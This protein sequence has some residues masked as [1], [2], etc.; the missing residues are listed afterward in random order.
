MPDSL[1]AALAEIAALRQRVQRLE[2]TNA[3]LAAR[4]ERSLDD[5]S[6]GFAM[7]QTAT[8]LERL[9]GERTAHLER[10]RRELEDTNRQLMA[11]K[12]AAEAAAG[13]KARF[14]ANM[15]HEIRTPMNGILGMTELLAATALDEH[16]RQMANTIKASADALL[17]VVNDVLDYSKI[18]AGKLELEEAT[19]DVRAVLDDCANLLATAAE[20]RG[21]E[22]V[23]YVDPRVAPGLRGDAARLRQI[24]LNLTGNAVKF[25]LEGQVVLSIDLLSE[26]ATTQ[27]LRLE[28][29]DT[30]VGI[31]PDT[32]ARL[33]TPFTQADA[34]TTRRFGGTGLGLAI[35]KHLVER[36][37][38]QIGAH[39]TVG[40]GSRFWIELTLPI[41]PPLPV[42]PS[43][44]F[45]RHAI[46]VVDD[47]ETNRELLALQLASVSIGIDLASDAEQALV[48]LRLA[49]ARGRPFTMAL[50]DMAMPDG[51][52]LALVEAIRRDPAIPPL[53]IAIASSL[54]HRPPESE[55]RRLR[56]AQWVGKPLGSSR[57]FDLLQELATDASAT[58]PPAAVPVEP[59][60]LAGC[61]VLVAEDNDINRRVLAGMLAKLG[62]TPTFAAD[63]REA[64][65]LAQKQRFDVILMDCRMPEMDGYAATSAIRALGGAAGAVPIV[66]L[67][68]N[69]LSQDRSACFASGMND[70][71]AKPVKLDVLRATLQRWVRP[72]AATANAGS[73]A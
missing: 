9:V 37:G 71:L 66:A 29:R 41:A 40:A 16:Q 52:G 44:T 24:L 31:D 21:V 10:L 4:V 30:G 43:E 50:I 25:T 19:F 47:N 3:A 65:A 49:A 22:V 23:I 48:I 26:T 17:V 15:S 11:A 6:A 73:G 60:S 5:G 38:G 51:D 34:S 39:S 45:A 28:V 58:P 68:A 69:V 54:S 46:L 32:L 67:T 13:A 70:F 7:F 53:A 62:C 2:R 63:G 55:L 61:E 36:M 56:I 18:E 57:L 42:V 12:E 59:V 8:N 35:S 14:L 1:E 20:Q 33:F 64:V 72:S 27:T